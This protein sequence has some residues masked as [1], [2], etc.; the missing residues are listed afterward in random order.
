MFTLLQ[1]SEVP[2]LV[3]PKNRSSSQVSRRDLDLHWFCRRI[4]F[5]YADVCRRM[6]T[7]DVVHV[8]GNGGGF[9]TRIL[10]YLVL[11][12]TKRDRW[13]LTSQGE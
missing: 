7:G 3:Y 5:S 4:P 11:F 6:L 8:T 1:Q 10:T 2:V 9:L 12:V 13:E